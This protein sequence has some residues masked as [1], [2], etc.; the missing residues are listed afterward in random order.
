MDILKA[1]IERKKRQLEEN[2]LLKDPKKKYFKRAELATKQAEEYWKKQSSIVKSDNTAQIADGEDRLKVNGEV[3][4]DRHSLLPRKEVIRKLRERNEPI[5]LFGE[6]DFDAYKRLKKLETSE[7]DIKNE[8][9][10]NDFQAAMEKVDQDYL[11]EIIQSTGEEDQNKSNDVSVKDDGTTLEDV[12]RM[13]QELGQGDKD[14][15]HEIVL[16]FFKFVLKKWGEQ[17]NTRPEEDKRT[18]KGK[19]A[20]A[21]HSQTVSYLKPL[22]RKLKYKDVD[23]G[24]LGSIVE[25]VQHMM[26]RNYIKAN[27]SYL[28]M[29]IG[30]APWPIGVT[31]VGIHARTGREKISSRYVAHVLNDETQR[32]Y[33]QAVKRLMTQCQNL[34]PTDPS[35]SYNYLRTTNK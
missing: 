4:S 28:E 27:D 35:R 12:A 34:F 6:D 32:K 26:D 23:E 16:R 31:M 5:R 19:M 22:F 21:T 1:E 13:R 17:L 30:N 20:S 10:S 33:I 14:K 8:G 9:Y 3:K 15:D 11:N 2:N 24:L 18:I 7:P 29:A 25:I